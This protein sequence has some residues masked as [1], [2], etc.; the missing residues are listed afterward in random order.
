MWKEQRCQEE[1]RQIDFSSYSPGSNAT[2]PNYQLF[3]KLVHPWLGE[4]LCE[5]SPRS[6]QPFWKRRFFIGFWV[7]PRWL[8]NH[9]TFFFSSWITFYSSWMDG[10]TCKVSPQSVQPRQRRFLKVYFF[11]NSMAAEWCD[12]WHQVVFCGPFYP[13]MTLKNF[14]TDQMRSTC[15]I[16]TS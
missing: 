5:V 2:I 13:E 12:R 4:H 8:P 3:L 16:M 7:N 15:A 9:V 10:H 14:H 1:P 6:V 11:Q